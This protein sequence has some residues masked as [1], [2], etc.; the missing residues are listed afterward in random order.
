MK[1]KNKK[2]TEKIFNDLSYIPKPIAQI[3]KEIGVGYRTAESHL[4]DLMKSNRIKEVIISR[5]R[6]YYIPV[7]TN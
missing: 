3:A 4:E 6:T 1:P 5:V 2:I 7:E